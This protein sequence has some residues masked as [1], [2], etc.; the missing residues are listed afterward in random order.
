MRIAII[1]L[2]SILTP[3]IVG[4][5]CYVSSSNAEIDLRH[6]IGAQQENIEVV[7]DKM[8]K[9]L[10]QKAG[11]ASEY[12]DAFSEIYPDLIA[13]RYSGERGGALMS[14]VTE[15]NPQFDTSLYMS[16]SQSIEA[17]RGEFA[18]EQKK[19]LDLGREHNAMLD[20]FPG[21]I[22][23]AGREKIEI[24]TV[25]SDRSKEALESGEDNDVDLFE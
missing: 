3:I 19:L 1:V 24:Q 14:W 15:H 7:H 17:L 20:K 21:I 25:T 16:L 6:R 12:K 18:R 13:G 2:I 9:T 10:Q 5:G 22:F 23:L 4:V 11:V 8:W